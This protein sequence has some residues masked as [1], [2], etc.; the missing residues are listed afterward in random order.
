VLLGTGR[1][2]EGSLLPDVDAV[3]S[4]LDD[5]AEV[6]R[7][8]CGVPADAIHQVLDPADPAEMDEAIRA[9]ASQP[10][11]VLLLYY[12]GHGVRCDRGRLHLATRATRN[13]TTGRAASQALEFRDVQ[14]AIERS[15]AATVMV[16]LDCCFSGKATLDGIVDGALFASAAP[17]ATALAP[18]GQRHTLFTGELIRLLDQGDS[19]APPYLTVSRVGD[20]LRRRLDERRRPRVRIQGNAGPLV[21]AGNR[22]YTP[23]SRPAEPEAVAGADDICPYLGLPAYTEDD[24]ERF[25]GRERQTDALLERVRGRLSRPFP[26]LVTGASGVGKSSLL[27][28]GLLARIERDGLGAPDSADWPRIR[29]SLSDDPVGTVTTAIGEELGTDVE[30]LISGDQPSGRFVLVVDQFEQ[31]FLQSAETEAQDLVDLLTGL[32]RS[33]AA[34]VVIGVRSDFYGACVDLRGLSSADLDTFFLRPLTE[35][36][37]REVITGPAEHAGL[38]VDD[39]LT[40]LI[41]RDIGARP[42][43][44]RRTTAMPRLSHALQATWQQRSGRRLTVAAYQ[45]AGGIDGSVAA[46]AEAVY[47]A[48]DEDGRHEARRILLE[49]VAVGVVPGVEDT[50]RTAPL[51]DLLRN[52][53][54]LD[55]LVRARLVTVDRD[56][57]Q[58]THETLFELWP[59]LQEWVERERENLWIRDRL[60]LDAQAWRG[61]QRDASFLYEGSRLSDALRYAREAHLGADE[62]EF[63]AAGRRRER[64]R[65]RRLRQ[66]IAVLAV[67]LVAAIGGGAIAIRQTGVAEARTREANVRQL[68]A[69]ADA[70]RD[71]APRTALHLDLAALTLSP[72][73]EYRTNLLQSLMSMRFGGQVQSSLPGTGYED[74]LSLAVSPDGRT[75]AAGHDDRTVSLWRIAGHRLVSEALGRFEVPNSEITELRFSADGRSVA[76]L[77]DQA[78]KASTMS[79]WDV[80]NPARPRRASM[81]NTGDRLAV[82]LTPDGRW[83]AAV[84]YDD[85]QRHG[86]RSPRLSLGRLAGP[87][88]VDYREVPRAGALHGFSQD[89]RL[90]LTSNSADAGYILWDI[91]DPARPSLRSTFKITTVE[92]GS[93]TLLGHPERASFSADSRVVVISK[94]G[95]PA[96]VVDISTPTRPLHVATLA[97]DAI[98]SVASSLAFAKQGRT[99]AVGSLGQILQLWDLSEPRQPRVLNA[100]G[101]TGGGDT[102]ALTFTPDGRSF[103]SGGMYGATSLWHLAPPSP[104]PLLARRDDGGFNHIRPVSITADGRRLISGAVL[105][106]ISV[107]GNPTAVAQLPATAAAIRPDGRLA[108]TRTNAGRV[109]LLDLT[110]PAHPRPT[111][112]IQ[113]H[114]EHSAGLVFSPD[115][116]TLATPE[117]IDSAATQPHVGPDMY[118]LWDVTDPK[119]P[120][121]LARVRGSIPW[122]PSRVPAF[123]F[124]PDGT[125]FVTAEDGGIILWDN[126]DRG[127]PGR[128]STVPTPNG[129]V[130][131]LA[132]SRD[133][134]RLAVGGDAGLSIWDVADR[135]RPRQLTHLKGKVETLAFSP[136]GRVLFTAGFD[137]KIQ[138]LS[139]ADP[140]DPIVATAV[141][142]HRSTVTGLTVAP[143]GRALVSRDMGG[144]VRLWNVEDLIGLVGD[145]QGSAC[146]LAKPVLDPQSWHRVVPN[147]PYVEVC[148]GQ[149]DFICEQ[150]GANRACWISPTPTTRRRRGGSR[151]VAAARGGRSRGDR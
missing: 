102:T 18:P 91:S 128:Q 151:V 14:K 149:S 145:P 4:S 139:V 37:L 113:L 40:D 87:A 52:G 75:V 19:A 122:D 137:N 66:S 57:A 120:T 89:G 45:A 132:Y 1:H 100:L 26:L 28:A 73:H 146:A 118:G 22:A 121:R 17:E 85:P 41:V 33:G 6:L 65:I 58:I 93:A 84:T 147:Q 5:L 135:T 27:R 140:T 39:E 131:T 81:V 104:P 136:D 35:E 15:P 94:D 124:S 62:T 16:F 103:L 111:A 68:V 51:T 8:R 25:F 76:V 97:D 70:V 30:A 80:T 3:A 53:A 133:G 110:D 71:R 98:T 134:R 144:E 55:A 34:V 123:A 92:A 88:V 95:R 36:E 130:Q 46:T 99:L 50:L 116:R 112:T 82:A 96:V 32:S 78:G 13:L 59:R 138:V 60:R 79:W 83:V 44:R 61:R 106:D 143:D 127:R 9:V 20:V 24:R 56:T 7:E 64:R 142:G 141:S 23:P 101:G 74:V 12:I 105:W 125:G 10:A 115:G 114:V 31:A 86:D 107:P 67:L 29:V 117:S 150:F 108:A 49:L 90:M 38:A 2:V 43:S 148:A 11:D 129:S 77:G 126:A 42:V 109:T 47:A 119:H 21:L 63:V 72:T 69:M 48:L 54:V